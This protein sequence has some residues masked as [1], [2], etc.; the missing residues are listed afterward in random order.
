MNEPVEPR[1]ACHRELGAVD[2]LVLLENIWTTDQQIAAL[3]D[4]HGYPYGTDRMIIEMGIFTI[5]NC[6][7]RL[8][9]VPECIESSELQ[10]EC[11]VMQH[12]ELVYSPDNQ[13]PVISFYT[14]DMILNGPNCPKMIR[15]VRAGL[16]G[17]SSQLDKETIRHLRLF[18]DKV[19]TGLRAKT[20]A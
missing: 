1:Y 8:I 13:V 5:L 12:A 18:I 6:I 11:G 20:P 10:V 3:F 16:R 19:I 7:D 14:L 2:R 17:T 4:E 9:N 15:L